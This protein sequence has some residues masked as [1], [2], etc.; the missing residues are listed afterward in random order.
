[1]TP[2]PL[3]QIRLRPNDHLS[4]LWWLGLLYRRPAQFPEGITSCSRWGRLA[5]ALCLYLHSLPY[6]LIAIVAGRWLLFGVLAIPTNRLL[7]NGTDNVTFHV[8]QIARGISYGIVVGMAGGIAV[9]IVV[10]MA[11]GIGVGVALGIAFGMPGGIA[12]GMAGGIGVGM[13]D[14]IGVGIALGVAFGIA[15][16]IA[17][18]I[19]GGIGVGMAA[20]TGV[21]IALG[22]AGGNALGIVGGIA[23]GIGVG[24]AV[25]RCFYQIVH[26]AFMWPHVQSRWYP[27][28]PVAWDD[29]CADPFPRL[30]RLLVA[31]AESAPE[32]GEME[33]E[34]LIET[35]K[36]Q[37]MAALRA[38]TRLIARE[39][40]RLRDLRLLSNLVAGLPEGE[41][42]FLK[43][44]RRLREMVGEIVHLQARLD[45]VDRPVFRE[46]LARLL[47]TEIENFQHRVSGFHEPLRSE[48][49]AAAGRWLDIADRQL[50]EAQFVVER[51][52][53]PQIFRAGD[54]VNREQEAFVPRDRVVGKLEQQVLLSTGCPGIVLYGRRRMGKSTVLR[55]LDGFLPPKVRVVTLSMQQA[56][57]LV[58]L[59]SLVALLG[60]SLRGAWPGNRPPE[61]SPRNQTGLS[62]LLS[63]CNDALGAEGRRL[64]L[65]FDEYENI[66][67]KIGE[68]V[69]PEDLLALVRESIQSHRNLTWAFAGSHEIDELKHAPWTS[70]LVS[71]RTIEV[72][73]FSEAETRLLLTEP[74]K[75]SSLWPKD[76]PSRPRPG[77]PAE[78]WGP[79]GIERIHAEAAGWPHLVQLIAETIVDLLNDEGHRQVDGGLFERALDEA[80]IR[81]HNVL[82]EL[83][84]RES[85][86]PGEWEYLSAFREQAAQ[87]APEDDAINRSLRRR[88]LVVE[89]TT[90]GP[91]RL[92]VPLM[93]RWLVKRG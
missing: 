60:E 93:R 48:F 16:G 56:E 61:S 15:L 92:R 66:D 59:E 75:F 52:P 9:G 24:V 77:F 41:K 6:S 62:D 82:Y 50:Q 46:T 78:F 11:F 65:A 88:M 25:S 14:G 22:I 91:L 36:S 40:G 47:R 72:P 76:D 87:A 28:H 86:L 27:F 43:Q 38:R 90:G 33:I 73:P 10:G 53:T 74:L 70:Y 67:R 71:A 2:R 54:P 29:L 37:R 31:Y 84:H 34:R 85:F 17:L 35:Y 39:S 89:E 44:T 30:D 26:P 1:M 57:A 23:L 45:T 51:K 55:N 80:I 68:R 79:G 42:G 49:R 3:G 64:I 5:I 19:A 13:A 69:F 58:S 32:A 83:M 12:F 21:G 63:V 81:G 20:G 7:T 4:A 8:M 18:G